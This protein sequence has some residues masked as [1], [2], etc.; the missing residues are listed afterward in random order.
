MLGR[1]DFFCCHDQFFVAQ[2][3]FIN[4]VEPSD[5]QW[6]IIKKST[7]GVF[8]LS[9]S[10]LNPVS[11][12]MA[13]VKDCAYVVML[14]D[15]SIEGVTEPGMIDSGVIFAYRYLASHHPSKILKCVMEIVEDENIDYLRDTD[16]IDENR[17]YTQTLFA[18]GTIFSRSIST[19][20]LVQSFYNDHMPR[21]IASLLSP[22]PNYIAYTG[23]ADGE[24][25]AH[26]TEEG[27]VLVHKT[28]SQEDAASH[29]TYP[30]LSMRVGHVFEP[31]ALD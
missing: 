18:Q 29:S 16:A 11:I 25:Y 26:K 17:V 20:L 8:F 2:V 3:L 12:E 21:I 28:I 23:D 4:D 24:P 7:S 14:A 6:C 10:P 31:R 13:N 1:G 19:T 30:A 9:A 27:P 22:T 5:K 15:T